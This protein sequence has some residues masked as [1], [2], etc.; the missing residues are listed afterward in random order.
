MPLWGHIQENVLRYIG[1]CRVAL[2]PSR[3]NILTGEV[4]GDPTEDTGTG[5]EV[6]ATG[7]TRI[8]RPMGAA[9]DVVSEEVDTLVG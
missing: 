4:I 5:I 8:D 7:R 3:G 2:D 6:A 1:I 9:H